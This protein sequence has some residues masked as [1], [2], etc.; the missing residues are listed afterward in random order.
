MKTVA[1]EGKK[2]HVVENIGFVHGHG[3]W[4]VEVQTENGDRIATKDS[5]IGSKWK[6]ADPAPI[7]IRG[8]IVGQ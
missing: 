4:A 6:W 5:M 8:H 3:C 2:Y 7:G 1:I